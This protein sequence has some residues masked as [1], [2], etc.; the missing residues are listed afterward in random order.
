[1]IIIITTTTNRYIGRG[2]N[3]DFMGRKLNVREMWSKENNGEELGGEGKERNKGEENFLRACV[4]GQN[5]QKGS[6]FYNI[7][8]KVLFIIPKFL[9]WG[10]GEKAIPQNTHTHTPSSPPL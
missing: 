8:K 6:L 9:V 4:R 2:G 5:D 1:M 3:F 10:I 7:T